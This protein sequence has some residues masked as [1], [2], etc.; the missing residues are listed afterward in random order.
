MSAPSLGGAPERSEGKE[1]ASMAVF[2]VQPPKFAIH[3]PSAI[4]G[5]HLCPGAPL[6]EVRVRDSGTILGHSAGLV[7]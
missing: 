3:A 6:E 2:F 1:A 4:S 5:A 7:L